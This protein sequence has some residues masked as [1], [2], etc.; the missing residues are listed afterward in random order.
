MR[1]LLLAILIVIV[2][3]VAYNYWGQ[4]HALP[5]FGGTHTVGTS[6]S[7]DTAKARQAGAELGEKAAAA[8]NKVEESVGEA[9][10]TSKIKAK[11]ALDD[12]V[13]A[14]TINVSTTGSTVTV[15]GHVRSEAERKRAIAL[16]RETS[17]V[18]QVIDHLVVDPSDR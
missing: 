15:S 3:V 5:A 1:G 8:A 10:I 6:G 4:S 11:M 7:V 16:A 17:G 13:R 2:A 14:R 9:A 18:T 12:T